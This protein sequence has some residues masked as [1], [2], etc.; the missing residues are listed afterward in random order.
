MKALV[1]LAV[2]M[3]PAILVRGISPPCRADED[4]PESYDTSPPVEQSGGVD[5]DKSLASAA[6]RFIGLLDSDDW[7]TRE[8]AEKALRR[9]G[10]ERYHMLEP[11]LRH[12][13]I[14][15]R[16]RI[17]RIMR[18][19]E[20]E[21]ADFFC[22]RV[23]GM[24]EY[25]ELRKRWR[26]VLDSLLDRRPL[27]RETVKHL[28][29]DTI[30][31]EHQNSEMLWAECRSVKDTDD[32]PH[33]GRKEMLRRFST[34]LREMAVAAYQKYGEE[35]MKP[36]RGDGTC[37]E[38]SEVARGRMIVLYR[39]IFGE[40]AVR[41]YF[42]SEVTLHCLER[43]LYVLH[44][45]DALDGFYPVHERELWQW[46]CLNPSDRKAMMALLYDLCGPSEE[47]KDEEHDKAKNF[48]PKNEEDVLLL[49]T[50]SPYFRGISRDL[51]EWLYLELK[52]PYGIEPVRGIRRCCC[53]RL[54]VH[55]NDLP[56]TYMLNT[57]RYLFSLDNVVSKAL[58]F[59]GYC[60]G[61]RAG[62]KPLP[63]ENVKTGRQRGRRVQDLAC[64]EQKDDL[65]VRCLKFLR[66]TLEKKQRILFDT[67]IEMLNCRYGRTNL[68]YRAQSLK[69]GHDVVLFFELFCA[70]VS[71]PKPAAKAKE[72]GK[73]DLQ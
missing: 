17:E 29:V 43:A 38:V 57:Y 10:P 6:Q 13:S 54:K 56:Q 15:V 3:I 8:A 32:Y 67:T 34:V 62:A 51:R 39:D 30:I 66:M 36:D 22:F 20:A 70:A 68:R 49:V 61:R 4:Y 35:G 24:P 64:V 21:D 45:E 50:R 27:K 71:G 41:A 73:G 28:K 7:E 16:Y 42:D 40:M 60:R 69:K 65:S 2:L 23:T 72:S 11:G 44:A 31:R 26:D 25:R 18:A 58:R 53:E 46:D 14:E 9:L 37:R 33:I 12:P 47:K 5:S 55:R 52:R 19:W 48:L 63:W 59:E 1:L